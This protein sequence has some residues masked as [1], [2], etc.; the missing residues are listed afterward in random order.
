M[1]TEDGGVLEDG[2]ARRGTEFGRRR[3]RARLKRTGG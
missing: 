2:F 1:G 3:Y